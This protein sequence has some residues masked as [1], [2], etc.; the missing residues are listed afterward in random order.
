MVD[1]ATEA[2]RR[3]LHNSAHLYSA[4]APA[5]SAQLMLKRHMEIAG[6]PGPGKID[7]SSS[8]CRACGTILVPGRTSQICIVK[9][10]TSEIANRKVGTKKR[11]RGRSSAITEKYVRT[12]CLACHRFEDTSIQKGKK[13][14]DRKAA[15]APLPVTSD[16]SAKSNLDPESSPL[17][18]ST[19][20]SKRRE[21][22]RKQKSGL[23]AM[24]EKSRTPAAPS[25]FGLDLMDLMKQR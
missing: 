7:V 16:S 10:P 23:Q 24:L 18:K 2:R 12:K 17:E 3:F 19:K 5:T 4:V 6:N 21:R 11:M 22:T 15:K 13:S 20:A 14:H 9:R 25:G 1:P 8:S